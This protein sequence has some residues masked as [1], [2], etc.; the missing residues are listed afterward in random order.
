MYLTNA[1]IQPG[2]AIPM[3]YYGQCLEIVPDVPLDL[4]L[5]DMSLEDGELEVGPS[6]FP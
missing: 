3:S 2:I 1:Y 4:A 6:T 5:K